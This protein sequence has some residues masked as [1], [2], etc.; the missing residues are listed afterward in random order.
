MMSEIKDLPFSEELLASWLDNMMT[1]E[2]AS[3]FEKLFIDN[4]DVQQILDANDAI[5][6]SYEEFIETN[7]ELPE[8]L[9]GDF[10]IPMGQDIFAEDEENVKILFNTDSENSDNDD[11]EENNLN[12]D[13]DLDSTEVTDFN[14]IDHTVSEENEECSHPLLDQS[15]ES[16]ENDADSFYN[17]FE[18][19][20][21]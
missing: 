7:E 16:S 9:F 10:Q 2:E 4:E 17:S 1:P 13:R 15:E 18:S 5:E 8:E 21:F 20:T 6:E 3:E 19:L 11:F 14:E 12:L